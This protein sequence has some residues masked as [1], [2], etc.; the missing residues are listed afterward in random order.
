KVDSLTQWLNAR[1]LTL[2]SVE[3][4]T[5]PTFIQVA[6]TEISALL[7]EVKRVIDAN[8]DA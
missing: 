8:G 2:A 3:L 1:K 5:R 7:D 4:L 6:S